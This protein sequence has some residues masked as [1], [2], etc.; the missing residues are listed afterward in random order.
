MRVCIDGKEI[1]FEGQ[2]TLLDVARANGI[3]IPS[4][5]DHPRLIPFSGCR[6]CLVQIKGRRGYLPA[7]S[8]DCEDGMVIKTQTPGIRRLRKQ[9]LELILSEHPNACLI[10]REKDNCD[11]FK[12]TIR[13]VGEVT[14]CVMCPN[15]GRCEL[16]ALVSEL[17]LA[18]VGF[19]SRYRDLE[20]RRGDPFFDRN[21]NLCILCGRCVRICREVRG[22]SILTFIQRGPDT[23]VGAAMDRP[24][25]EAGCQFCGACVDVCPTGA[26]TE[27]SMK[28]ES[29]PEAEVGAICPLCG[30]GC[31]M[32]IHT[33][34][35]R[36]LY[37]RPAEDGPVNRGQACVKGRFLL[38]EVVHS[39]RRIGR[40][41][42]RK[43]R[44]W[45]E[46]DWE[47]ALALVAER[48]KTYRPEQIGLVESAQASCE[49]AYVLRRLAADI[50]GTKNLFRPQEL[51]PL[52]MYAR[53]LGGKGLR[54]P[55]NHDAS[56]LAEADPIV[57][58][59]SGIVTAQPLAWL[60]VVEAVRRGTELIVV[61]P[62]KN[63]VVG[64]FASVWHRLRPGS[65]AHFLTGMSRF[66]AKRDDQA[67]ADDRPGGVEFAAALESAD[68][69]ELIRA[70]GLGRETLEAASA[71][72]AEAR[73]PVFLFGAETAGRADGDAVLTALWN[74]ALQIRGRLLPLG[75]EANERGLLEMDR[76]RDR[77]WAAPERVLQKIADKTIRALYMTGPLKLPSRAKPEFLVVQS[78]HWNEAAEAA[79]VVLPAASFGEEEGIFVNSGGRLQQSPKILDPQESARPGWRILTGLAQRIKRPGLTYAKTGDIWKDIRAEN[80]AFKRVTSTFLRCGGDAHVFEPSP[81]LPRHLAFR[82]PGPVPRATKTYPLLL[83]HAADPDSYR[84]LSLSRE[85]RGFR[86]LREESRFRLNP[87]DADR[88]ELRERDD[89]IVESPGGTWPG[90]VRLDDNVMPGTLFAALAA[91]RFS[92]QRAA[93]VLP[94]RLKR[95]S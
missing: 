24:M 56:V 90:T 42:V 30:L 49:E 40:P 21:Y 19:P 69:E 63:P 29:L 64:R 54:L 38:K 11:E 62:V 71:R 31:R 12:S 22:P 68:A 7:C 79:H 43:R 81:G 4:L 27:K 39:S 80:P 2:P 45:E 72:L 83:I 26:L 76:A 88:H 41:L 51:S 87:E 35:N 36:V 47:T 28:Y 18:R 85:D 95:G 44:E 70:A 77:N 32:E 73:S 15:N 61:G 46:T 94:A 86:L 60:E 75:L 52:G 3:F 91:F 78:S 65:E 6:L 5:C 9:I 33:R 16:Q 37:S 1:D 17:G 92:D 20:V 67:S 8:T 58:L 57:M 84:G 82:L 48:L 53:L 23:V 13:K 66:L 50:L 34:G 55:L 89:V 25:L 59:G 74:L 10:C 93:H 14:G